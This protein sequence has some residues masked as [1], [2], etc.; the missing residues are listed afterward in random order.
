MSKELAGLAMKILAVSEELGAV[1]KEKAG[2]LKYQYFGYEQLNAKLRVLLNKHKLALIPS[3]SA[4][5]EREIASKTGAKYIR[6]IVSGSM[7]IIDAETGASIE[8]SMAGADQDYGGK[9]F[10]QAFTEAVKR[11]ELKFFH[12]STEEDIDPDSK[13]TAEPRKKDVMLPFGETCT[14]L[15]LLD[16]VKVINA[17]KNRKDLK[18]LKVLSSQTIDTLTPSQEDYV[19]INKG[20]FKK[21]GGCSL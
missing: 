18:N 7:L 14:R 2:G 21:E 1:E 12:V 8:R 11:F 19:D 16:P 9:S 3:I 6:T 13:Q 20:W 4:F 17:L 15:L 10:G 5:E